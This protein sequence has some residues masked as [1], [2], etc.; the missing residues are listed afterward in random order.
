MRYV[1]RLLESRDSVQVSELAKTLAVS[2]VTVRGD[3]DLLASQGLA[4][5]VRGGIRML[6]DGQSD[7]AFDLRLRL[8]VE[9]KRAIAR[10]VAAMVDDGEAVALDAGT[11][12]YYVAQRLRD[13]RELV[14]VTNGLRVATV[15]ADAPGV[16]VLVTGGVLRLEAMS[17]VGDL[18]TSV[19][20][21]TRINKGFLG[22][23]GL[24][25]ERGL[26]DLNPEEVRRKHEIACACEQ[27][28]GIVDGT[29]WQRS[30]LLSFVAV[31]ELAGVVTDSSAPIE[32]VEAWRG[33]GVDVITAESA[34]ASMAE[35]DLNTPALT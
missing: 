4:A 19:L 30:A 21:T 14:V 13:R 17:L 28:Y 15:L 20:R 32:E 25:L 3:L 27:I 6:K 7:L 31:E 26:M 18:G 29:K 2:E 24:S 8:A 1:L 34:G 33:A 5:R 11:T 9:Q 23:R 12:A 22:A 16:T 35:G 10:A